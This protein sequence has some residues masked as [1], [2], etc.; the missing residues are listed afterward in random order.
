MRVALANVE[1]ARRTAVTSLRLL[2]RLAF[3]APAC[4]APALSFQPAFPGLNFKQPVQV[5]S[6]PDGS[7]RLFVVEQHGEVLVLRPGVKGATVAL[8]LRG[9]VRLD[10]PEEGLLSLAFHPDF[11]DNGRAF[12]WYS[13]PGV[14]PRRNRLAEFKADA[15]RVR[16]LPGTE[17]VLLEVQKRWGNHNG[18]CL[19]F[20]PDGYL[21]FGLGDGGSHGDPLGNAQNTHVLLGKM[22]RLDVD[23]HAPGLPYGIPADN[24]FARGGGRPEIFAWGLRNPW[25][26]SFDAVTGALWVGDVGQDRWE[27]IDIVQRGGNYGWNWREGSHPFKSGTP[28]TG[29]TD[30]IFDYGRA[31]GGC[32]TGGVVVRGGPVE[33]LRGRYLFG[34]FLSRRFWSLNADSMDPTSLRYEGRC[35]DAPTSIDLDAAGNVWV[36]GYGGTLYLVRP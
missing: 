14:Q 22:L 8:D 13:V 11:G 5:V 30:P 16:L 31:K 17:K 6:P 29:L 33:S 25:R 19:R 23:K 32:V 26:M 4:L 10:D 2:L 7:G 34:D 20:G 24:P 28:P 9:K 1:A 3:L 12:V 15:S 35:P 36:C 27:E 21:Y 18:S